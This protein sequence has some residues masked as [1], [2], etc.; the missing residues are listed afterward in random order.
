MFSKNG[1]YGDAG[2]AW[3]GTD[4]E[5][6]SN[7]ATAGINITDTA[8]NLNRSYS[9]ATHITDLMVSTAADTTLTLSGDQ[10]SVKMRHFTLSGA[11][12]AYSPRTPI[13]LITGET[14]KLFTSS[15]TT[16]YCNTSF[17]HK[18]GE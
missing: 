8:N 9:Y 15:A 11:P 6:M 16:V 12:F 3:N 17:F 13:E 7:D 14:L 18:K 4:K 10:S 1:N 5:V 2:P